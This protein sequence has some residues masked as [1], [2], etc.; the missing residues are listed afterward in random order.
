MIAPT[1]TY[2]V[3]LHQGFGFDEARALVD[4]LDA[5]GISHVYAS[6]YLKAEAGSTH[7]YN[8]VDPTQLNPEIGTTE[9]F[10]AW[11]DAL[12][13][14]GMGHVVD[15]VPNHMG[16]RTGENAWWVDVLENGPCSRFADYFDIDWAPPKEGL[17]GR[18]LLPILGAA[19]G[20]VLERGELRISRDGG[21]FFVDYFE[22]RLPVSSPTLAPLLGRA[23]ARLTLPKDDPR[24]QELESIINSLLHLPKSDEIAQERREERAR[25]KEVIK[26]RLD[27]ACRTGGEVREA[28]DASVAEMNGKDGDPRSFDALDAFLREQCYRLSFWRVATEE[29]N[30]RRFFEVN[31]LAAVRMERDSVF[32]HAHALL[33]RLLEEGRLDGLRLDHTD[34]LH[35]PALYFTKL[36]ARA[37]EALARA[38]AAGA[39]PSE[40]APVSARDTSRPL[41]VVAEKILAPGEHLPDD[42][43]I[44]GTTGYEHGALLD[45]LWVDRAA[46]AELTALYQR[47]TGDRASFAEHVLAGKRAVMSRSL[48][49]EVTTLARELSRIAEEDRR[50]RDFTLASLTTAIV[51]TIAHFAVYRTYVREDGSRGPDD[52]G[53]V[54]RA[55]RLA[56]RSNREI[57]ASVFDFLRDV[58]LLRI[59]GDLLPE[60]RAARAAFAM[61]FQQLTGPV[62]AKGLEDTAFY[63]YP[64]LVSL[65]E[66]GSRADRFGVTVA[67][68]HAENERRLRSFPLGMTA[69]S[70]HDSK[71]GEDARARISV[72][73]EIPELW[74]EHV[75]ALRASADR[76]RTE[77]DEEPTPSGTDEYL[78]YQTLAG[79]F[80]LD[81]NLEGFSE[82]VVEYMTKAAR[83]AKLRTSWLSPNEAYEQAL[84]EFVR[85]MLGDA[86]VL[87][88]LR[89][90]SDHIAAHG[91]ANG[92]AQAVLKIA[93]PGVPDTYQG[94]E[95]WNLSLV[96]PDNRRPVDYTALRALLQRVE[97][98]RL[99]DLRASFADGGLKLHVVRAALRL[100]REHRALFIEGAYAPIDAGEHVV[101]F[102]RTHADRTLVCV[103]ARHGARMR[104]G[105]PGWSIGAAWGDREIAL[106]PARSYRCAISGLTFPGGAPARL[107]EVFADLPVALLISEM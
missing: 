50:S 81:D 42:W 84:S 97:G 36:Q 54:G 30:Y 13:A 53:H 105:A 34:G 72:L 80:P 1:S 96:D 68:F 91:A 75:S 65:N 5:L 49:S 28:I 78:L 41:F 90:L 70:T 37:G 88:R 32:D 8:L 39:P 14:R 3:Q 40:T 11:T 52:E 16:I 31:D 101:A 45:G 6:P 18:V 77:V 56:R 55:T 17:R 29:I 58:L 2:R 63:T 61:R 82:R 73:S 60:A 21:A 57:N 66:V 12:R 98:A 87:S 10:I 106:P 83:E 35:D 22:R 93:S 33:F 102:T 107:A 95:V 51:E 47:M 92:L 103:T 4:Y 64:R 26:R 23:A 76:Y 86:E 85:S 89:A 20:E 67:E 71:R 43:A 74:A 48:S 69:S 9:A 79:S 94:S 7:G 38:A 100:R 46:E 27:E 104:G 44:H 25:E 59:K 19:Y 24:V 15:F 99:E 62:M